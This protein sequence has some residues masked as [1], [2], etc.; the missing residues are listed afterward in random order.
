MAAQTRIMNVAQDLGTLRELAEIIKDPKG[1]IAAHEE[2]RKQQALTDE[3]ARKAAE[4]KDFIAKYNE[5]SKDIAVK[6]TK[7]ATDKIAHEKDKVDTAVWLKNEVD[8]LTNQGK[9]LDAKTKI[10]ADKDRAQLAERKA[11]NEAKSQHEQEFKDM[12]QKLEAKAAADDKLRI[13]NENKASQLAD[14]EARLNAK[15]TRL[16][17]AAAI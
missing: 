9:D 4:A 6:Q 11:L 3:E 14:K 17:E 2:A 7:L 10:Q 5:L 8:R 13:A 15:F 12:L 16:Q 1:L